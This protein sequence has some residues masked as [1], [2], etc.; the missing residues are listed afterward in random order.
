MKSP[1]PAIVTIAGLLGLVLTAAARGQGTKADYDRSA[2]LF[3]A[4]ANKVRQAQVV[5]HWSADGNACWYATA[6]PGDAWRY[7]WVDAVAGTRQPAVDPA[8]LAAALKAANVLDLK[9]ADVAIDYLDEVAP[10]KWRISL[11]GLAAN[12]GGDGWVTVDRDTYRLTEFGDNFGPAPHPLALVDATARPSGSDAADAGAGRWDVTPLVLLNR[13]GRP[14]SLSTVGADGVRYPFIDSFDDHGAG[15]PFAVWAGSVMAAT[16]PAGRSLGQWLVTRDGGQLVVDPPPTTEPATRPATQPAAPAA[17]AATSPDGRWVVFPRDGEL[18]ARDQQHGGAEVRLDQDGRVPGDGYDTDFVNWSPDGSAVVG[19]R[20]V[21]GGVTRYVALPRP[22]SADPAVAPVEWVPTVQ[23]GDAMAHYELRLFR[24]GHKSGLWHAVTI[25]AADLTGVGAVTA[26]N[27]APDGTRFQ[28]G[29]TDRGHQRLAVWSVD[30]GTGAARPVV[31]ERSR[32]FILGIASDH[33]PYQD[34][35][36]NHL[37]LASEREGRNALYLYDTRA[38]RLLDR[39]TPGRCVV[40]PWDARVDAV[41]GGDES[42]YFRAAGVDPEQDPYYVHVCR[43]TLDGSGFA[44]LTPADGTHAVQDSP[45]GRFYLDTY[46]RVDLPPAT[47]L[48]RYGD[49]SLLCH[50]EQADDHEL[51]AT[52]WRYPERFTAKGRDGTTDIFG[53]IYRPSNFDPKKRYPVVEDIYAGPTQFSVPKAFTPYTYA[54][55][56]AELGFV[57]VQIDG[58]GTPG[59]G[60]AFHDVCWHNLGDCG[61]DDR[62]AWIRAAAAKHPEM[63]LSHGVGVEGGS[64]GGYAAVRALEAHPE[65]YTVAVA[66]DG[67]YDPR[68]YRQWYVEQW[69]GW[70]LGPWYDAASAATTVGNIRGKLLLISDQM[71]RNVDPAATRELVAALEAAG[72]DFDLVTVPDGDHMGGGDYVDRRRKDFLVRHLM[73]VEPRA[74]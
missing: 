29:C 52:G 7:W 28:F 24:V 64:F 71:D 47:D 73:G 43:A 39:V 48:R 15:S 37:L 5:P 49:G 59:R 8:R 51:L 66:Q 2:G 63:D 33:L 21:G 1:N 35:G 30:A 72:K 41:N 42:V 23:A 18:W 3:G 11:R 16:D 13:T 19:F 38:G 26:A 17:T 27:W 20:T 53:V 46:S 34:W 10:G 56:I 65:L 45:D 14:V 6:G 9:P 67:C 32:S 36:S 60:K 55:S 74:R 25:T 58:M 70:P 44:D 62:V 31:D 61:L 22:P 57:V 68:L 54:M 4:T 50:L 40:Q 69:M 12:P